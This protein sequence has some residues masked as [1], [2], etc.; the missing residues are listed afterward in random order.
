MSE[1][2][3]GFLSQIWWCIASPRKAFESIRGEDLWKGVILILLLASLSAWAGLGYASKLDIK[4][5]ELPRSSRFMRP[6]GAI[7]V[8][9]F[10][11]N[12]MTF[13]ALREGFRVTAGW[14]ISSVLL[15][16]FA[17]FLA[18]NGSLR[19]TFA[20][21]GFASIPLLFQQILRL[22][23]AYTIP[24]GEVSSLIAARVLGLSLAMRLLSGL[25]AVFTI[26]GLWTFVLTVVAV[27]INYESSRTRTVA[28]TAAA[29][30]LF[31]A[32]RLFLPLL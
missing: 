31:I 12:V 9:V 5:P 27:S 32:V 18:G 13:Y 22:L 2:K 24:R 6:G 8:E 11:R 28:A 29:Y 15:H 20:L 17:S 3:N 14:L 16:L 7:D 30:L 4:P 21:T 19:R 26:F 1:G 23:D 25:L 10:R